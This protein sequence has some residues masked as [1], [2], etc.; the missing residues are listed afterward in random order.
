MDKRILLTSCLIF[1]SNGFSSDWTYCKFPENQAYDNPE[2]SIRNSGKDWICELT[3]D[4]SGARCPGAQQRTCEGGTMPGPHDVPNGGIA[5]FFGTAASDNLAVRC[6]CGC[7]APETLIASENGE[8]PISQILEAA[9]FQNVSVKVR[10]SFEAN[11]LF[12]DSA[13]MSAKSFRVG[14]ENKKLVVIKMSNGRTL[15]LTSNHPVI[16]NRNDG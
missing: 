10:E 2:L 13:G 3:P 9:K 7:F 16:V 12:R 8:L 15:R 11:H 5:W 14:P 1:S 6:T 4:V